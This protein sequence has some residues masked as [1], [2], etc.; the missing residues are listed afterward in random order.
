M[1]FCSAV[2]LGL[3]SSPAGGARSSLGRH[4]APPARASLKRPT[5]FVRLNMSYRTKGLEGARNVKP[6]T[7]EFMYQPWRHR[8]GLKPDMHFFSRMPRYLARNLRWVRGALPPQP[9]TLLMTRQIAVRF[10][11]T[12]KPKNRAIVLP[13]V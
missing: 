2:M 10:C 8:A 6:S 5:L 7:A 11:E 9:T 4:R 12:S 3:R 13:P 1:I